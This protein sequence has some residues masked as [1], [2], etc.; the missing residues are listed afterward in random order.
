LQPLVKHH[1]IL[2]RGEH[3]FLAGD[4]FH[5]LYGVHSGSIKVYALSDDGEEQVFGFYLPGEVIGLDAI[6]ERRHGFAAVAL[7]TSYSVE[8]P[9]AELQTRCQTSA[10]LQQYLHELYGREIARECALLRLRSKKSATGRLARFL[11]DIAEEFN[12]CMTRHEIGNYLGL[13]SETVSRLFTRLQHKGIISVDKRHVQIRDKS[14]LA[15]LAR[16]ESDQ[17]HLH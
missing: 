15:L 3:L 13:A 7:E 6:N 1:R 12:L 9:Y 2:R 5:C 14:M 16:S 11:L 8:I 10:V 17:L 4:P